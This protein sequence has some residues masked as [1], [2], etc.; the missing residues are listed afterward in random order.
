MV[1]L[2]DWGKLTEDLEDLSKDELKEL[3]YILDL[4]R[5]GRK[6]ELI[7]NVLDSDYEYQYIINKMNFLLF[8]LSLRRYY[9]YSELTRISNRL[10]LIKH[11][12]IWDKM[13]EIIK[14]EEI[15]PLSLIGKLKRDQLEKLY[16]EIFE[17]EPNHNREGLIKI[18][19]DNLNLGYED[20]QQEPYAEQNIDFDKIYKIFI[21]HKT[22]EKPI[23]KKVLKQLENNGYDCWLDEYELVAGDS[24]NKIF[25]GIENCEYFCFLISKSSIKSVWCRK[26]LDIAFIIN[27]E[28]K[29]SK[30]IPILIENVEVPTNIKDLVYVD[31]RKE[32]FDNGIDYLLHSIKTHDKRKL[33]EK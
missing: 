8:G 17:E 19:I 18:I 1:E 29:G 25:S 3:C 16:I 11:N 27:L 14:S 9:S 6:D 7:Q 20:F 30:I 28:G 5:S 23:A 10:E 4:N 21:C 12:N 2:K 33:S 26:E 13:V 22:E 31:C 32:N 15:D 24:L